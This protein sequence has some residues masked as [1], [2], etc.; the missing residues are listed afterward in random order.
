[1]ISALL[2]S[3]GY[4]PCYFITWYLSKNESWL[5]IYHWY[6]IL[7][8][9]HLLFIK[10]DHAL[11]CHTTLLSF[12]LWI[13]AL[14]RPIILIYQEA[15]NGLCDFAHHCSIFFFSIQA[16]ILWKKSIKK[17]FFLCLTFYCLVLKLFSPRWKKTLG[18]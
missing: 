7:N 2:D 18:L 17:G 12:M 13:L 6:Q 16:N 10:N 5:L 4:N 11:S 15:E 9:Q 14:E 1:M 8:C 3:S